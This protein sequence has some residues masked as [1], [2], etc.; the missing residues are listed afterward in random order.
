MTSTPCG[1]A[2]PLLIDADVLVIGGGLAGT[3]AAIAASREGARVVL[4]EK[5][6]CG[7][8]GVTATAGPNHW[9]V[10]P[11][12]REAVIAARLATAEGLA[13]SSWMAGI[14]DLTW[15]SLPSLERVYSFPVD[16]KGQKQYRTL[17]GPEYMRAMRR[18]ALEHKVIL[19][20]QSPALELLKDDQ[21][22]LAGARGL[23][24]Q[25]QREWQV[26]ARAVVLATGGCAFR[27]RLL[28]SQNNTGDGL[29]M[30]VEAGADLSGMEFSN[31]YCIA[32]ASS[33][34]TR[35]MIYSFGRF[36]D[37]A[38]R[39]FSVRYEHNFN[40]NLARALLNGPVYCRLDRIPET[41]RTSLPYVQPNT[42]LA[43]DRW[44]ID[45][46]RDKFPITLHVEGTVRGVGGLRLIDR[47]CQTQVP[48]LFAVGDA[49][50]REAVT[51]AVSGA[52]AVNASW[53]LSSGQWAGR[54][55]AL[56]ASKH[57]KRCRRS[58]GIARVGLLPV[59]NGS[60]ANEAELVRRIQ[61][62]MHPFEK[63][64]FRSGGQL[65]R[66]L[67]ALDDAWDRLRE[68]RH[69]QDLAA[70][71]RWREAAA[72]L[73]AARWC[74]TSALQRRESRGM[75]QRIDIPDKSA[76]FDLHMYSGGLDAPW[77]RKVLPVNSKADARVAP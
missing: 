46:Y 15:K 32:P 55:A 76:G 43:F 73:A 12:Q 65:R 30:G 70:V 42:M 53:A 57:S 8:S 36:F 71:L 29:L 27:S 45:P 41:L 50:S 72:M 23:Q 24:R 16:E 28:G 69:A 7:T 52:G 31:F 67:A 5:G 62:E 66:S 11:E 56:H 9:W 48:G 10:A 22:E 26:H 33:G 49:A 75:H 54:G 51:G 20:D 44:G 19:L 47:Q 21:G 6:Y 40:E 18:F 35:A 37:A 38:G 4:A 77:V 74:Y 13:D 3:W 17:R 63:N 58:Q 2:S 60:C 14:L 1:S 61:A 59:T 34:M 68:Q 39:E 64:M 25:R